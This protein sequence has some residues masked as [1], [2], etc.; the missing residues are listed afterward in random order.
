MPD[1]DNYAVQLAETLSSTAETL[2][3]LAP[4]IDDF[5]VEAHSGVMSVVAKGENILANRADAARA[6]VVAASR[7]RQA[8]SLFEDQAHGVI[9]AA[10]Q[11]RA[12]IG[13]DLFG[14]ETNADE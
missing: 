10:E 7:M 14:D 1:I 8:L 13:I 6:A 4:P 11:H 9:E 2:A 3:K 12:Q 5:H